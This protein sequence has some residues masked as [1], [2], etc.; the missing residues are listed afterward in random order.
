MS[1]VKTYAVSFGDG[2]DGISHIFPD[3]YVT[4]DDPWRLARLAMIFS[5]RVIPDVHDYQ[6]WAAE[7]VQLDE[8]GEDCVQ[9]CLY[10]GPD[11]VDGRD[12]CYMMCDVWPDE[13]NGRTPEYDSI[14]ACFPAD[15]IARYAKD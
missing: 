4:T 12:Y 13:P 6:A 8:D 2:N 9:A 15:F 3:Y 10:D 14:E 7:N 5:F 11:D 1:D